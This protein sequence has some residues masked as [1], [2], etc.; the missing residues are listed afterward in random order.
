MN[1]VLITRYISSWMWH[2]VTL[3]FFSTALILITLKQFYLLIVA[4]G[5]IIVAE[6]FAW[7]RKTEVFE[8][9]EE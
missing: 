5:I 1:E 3:M 4:I 6:S 7:K 2:L 9:E 8:I